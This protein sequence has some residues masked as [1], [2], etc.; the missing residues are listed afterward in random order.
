L[1]ALSLG[2]REAAS[3]NGLYVIYDLGQDIQ[4][5]ERYARS[6]AFASQEANA[7]VAAILD[8]VG[9]VRNG[10]PSGEVLVMS[11]HGMALLRTVVDRG[12]P[13]I[14]RALRREPA[15]SPP[16]APLRTSTSTFRSARAALPDRRPSRRRLPGARF[17]AGLVLA[18]GIRSE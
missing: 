16:R 6:L 17:A 1:C 5:I 4:R 8:A 13:L 14:A 7:A 10:E 15:P 12:N 2:R 18:I 3:E 11:D 9:S